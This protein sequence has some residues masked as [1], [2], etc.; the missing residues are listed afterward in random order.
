M[1]AQAQTGC[2]AKEWFGDRLGLRVADCLL[3]STSRCPSRLAAKGHRAVGHSAPRAPDPS[4]ASRY[5]RALIPAFV[6][7]A[8]MSEMERNKIKGSS[9]EGMN[10]WGRQNTAAFSSNALT[11]RAGPPTKCAPATERVSA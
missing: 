2:A 10:P 11:S 9:C 1:T 5:T 4:D 6:R 7:D 8:A 3:V